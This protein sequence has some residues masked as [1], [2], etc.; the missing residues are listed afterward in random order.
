MKEPVF[1]VDG[2]N[3]IFRSYYAIPKSLSSNGI[4]TNA[5]YG[6][7]IMIR[8][9]I[10]DYNPKYLAIVFDTGKKTFRHE[11][12]PKYKA[13]R[14]PS[15]NDLNLQFA[16]IDDFVDA[17]NISKFRQIGFEADDIIGTLAKKLDSQGHPVV[18]A[19]S[20]KDMMQLVSNN[21]SLLHEFRSGRENVK[22]IIKPENV[23]SKFGVSPEYVA[24]ILALT[25][26]VSDN[27]PGVS[28][29][30]KKNAVK[31]VNEYGHIEEIMNS[32]IHIKQKSIREKLLKGS[33]MAYL[34]KQLASINCNVNIDFNLTELKN[35][36]PNIEKLKILYEKCGFSK[37]FHELKMFN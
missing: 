5:A 20:D 15:P 1:I 10:K 22:N 28:G 37:L 34:S 16:L 14:P 19:T 33:A 2:S 9:I 26:D 23:K 36:K 31:L 12:Y 6:F 18:I 25:G 29:I 3:Y 17:F 21:V 11:I 35:K 4:P 7:C 24:D 13:H 27:I 32:A 8:K 30:G